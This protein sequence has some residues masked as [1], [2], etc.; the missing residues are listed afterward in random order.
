[1]CSQIPKFLGHKL[2]L[3]QQLLEIPSCILIGDNSRS[4]IQLR[5]NIIN[6][7]IL[8]LK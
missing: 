7:L 3:D 5:I 8:E 4:F 6:K 2:K 1:M